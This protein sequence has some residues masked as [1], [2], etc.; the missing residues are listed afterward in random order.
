M[1]KFLY[2]LCC[3][4]CKALLKLKA[5]FHWVQVTFVWHTTELTHLGCKFSTR[6]RVCLVRSANELSL[7]MRNN[8]LLLSLSL[9]LSHERKLSL[10]RL[11]LDI[12]RH[13]CC[14][15]RTNLSL[16][17]HVQQG[18]LPYT[19]RQRWR[20]R[21]VLIYTSIAHTHCAQQYIYIHVRACIFIMCVWVWNALTNQANYFGF[22]EATF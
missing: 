11:K 13:A 7:L 10:S 14:P 21:D 5:R 4:C 2:T 3:Y 8:A 20:I 6:S 15:A 1:P 16:S 19:V 17:L 12:D 18:R 22:M 9:C